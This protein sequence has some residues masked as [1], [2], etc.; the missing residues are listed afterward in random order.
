MKKLIKKLSPK[1]I[2][3]IVYSFPRGA[4]NDIPVMPFELKVFSENRKS[5]MPKMDK[6]LHSKNQCYAVVENGRIVHS[7]WLFE[8]T[9]LTKQ[10]GEYN[11]YTAGDSFTL[12]KYRGKGIYTNVL[13]AIVASCN[14]DIFIYVE[15]NNIASIK[16]IEKAGFCK[17]YSFIMIR[18]LGIKVWCRKYAIEY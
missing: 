12:E 8:N 16:A 4:T 5:G 9:L 3:A 13:K 15:P 2:S 7:T 18:F 11:V 17:R 10:L 6:K 1:K 14:K